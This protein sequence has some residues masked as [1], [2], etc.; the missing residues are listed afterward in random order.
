MPDA[1]IYTVG[2]ILKQLGPILYRTELSN[3]KWVMG[4]LSK[5]L[6]LAAAVFPEGA[7]VALEMTPYDFDQARI[8]GLFTNAE[9]AENDT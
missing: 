1:P 5:P 8:L 3:G 2:I 9:S 4:H 7:K 6:T